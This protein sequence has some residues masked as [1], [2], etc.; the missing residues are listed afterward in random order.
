MPRRSVLLF[1]GACIVFAAVLAAMAGASSPALAQLDLEADGI[2]KVA[3]HD[4]DRAEKAG[5]PALGLGAGRRAMAVDDQFR[6]EAGA[7]V[8]ASARQAFL[9]L[10]GQVGDD[11]AQLPRQGVEDGAFEAGEAG[12]HQTIS[13]GRF[14]SR[15]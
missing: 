12:G 3:D 5:D 8:A 4:V 9:H 7:G 1:A 2:L 11:V 6:I 14:T 10:A 13:R 15:H